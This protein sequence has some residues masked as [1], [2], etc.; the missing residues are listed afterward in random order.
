M[1][2]T[3]D[4]GILKYM[5]D[6]IQGFRKRQRQLDAIKEVWKKLTFY[7]GFLEAKKDTVRLYSGRGRG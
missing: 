1:L 6:F 7:T 3:V 5:M 4:L 2:H